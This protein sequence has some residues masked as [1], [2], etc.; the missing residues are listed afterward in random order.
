[1][2]QLVVDRR[3]VFETSRWLL[4]HL[5]PGGMLVQI[6]YNRWRGMEDKQLGCWKL[7]ARYHLP[8]GSVLYKHVCM[9]KRNFLEQTLPYAVHLPA[10]LAETHSREKQV[11]R[12]SRD[13]DGSD[14]C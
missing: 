9:R 12:T 14:A 5:V 4:A 8:D 2:N 6:V 7:S 1:M 3:R 11:T 13:T 10:H